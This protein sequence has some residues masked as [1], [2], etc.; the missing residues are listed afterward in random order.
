MN[1]AGGG[2]TGLYPSP[3]GPDLTVPPGCHVHIQL[4]L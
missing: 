2:K 1:A 4:C 3:S